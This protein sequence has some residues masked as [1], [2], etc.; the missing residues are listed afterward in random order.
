MDNEVMTKP[1]KAIQF[2]ITVFLILAGVAL[3]FCSMFIP[4][5]GEIHPSVLT[6]FGM[7]LTFVGTTLGIDYN[8]KTKLFQI[9]NQKYEK[10]K[11]N[12]KI[13]A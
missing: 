1:P 13:E 8:Y 6:A 4:P 3:L 12:K 2:F 10:V 7:I 11:R 9:T 5:H